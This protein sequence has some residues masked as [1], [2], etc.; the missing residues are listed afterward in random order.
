MTLEESVNTLKHHESFGAFIN[1]IHQMREDAIAELHEASAEQVQ[2]IS[3]KILAY[4]EVLRM[5][6]YEEIQR[7]FSNSLGI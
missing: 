5:S 2:K 6:N 4:D 3:G 7:R 1:N